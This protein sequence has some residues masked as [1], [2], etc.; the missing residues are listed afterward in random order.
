MR[1]RKQ[2]PRLGRRR[3]KDRCQI[4]FADRGTDLKIAQRHERLGRFLLIDTVGDNVQFK[5]MGDPNTVFAVYD[6]TEIDVD[7]RVQF[8]KPLFTTP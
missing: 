1:A 4:T 3:T 7:I 6:S 8:L 2:R 5:A